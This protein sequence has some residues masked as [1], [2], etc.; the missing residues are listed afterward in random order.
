M[1]EGIWCVPNSTIFPLIIFRN[2]IKIYSCSQVAKFLSAIS[3]FSASEH[4]KKPIGTDLSSLHIQKEELGG[5]KTGKMAELATE[6]TKIEA[7]CKGLIRG[8]GPSIRTEN[9]VSP[10]FTYFLGEIKKVKNIWKF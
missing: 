7:E 2:L 3:A 5:L 1:N 6:K 8:A 9:L 10:I 4:L